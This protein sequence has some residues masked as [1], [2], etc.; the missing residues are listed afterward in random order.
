MLTILIKSHWVFFTLDWKSSLL[1][2]STD[3]VSVY[4]VHPP[5]VLKLTTQPPADPEIGPN[6]HVTRFPNGD[7][8]AAR[9]KQKIWN[10]CKEHEHTELYPNL[11]IVAGFLLCQDNDMKKSVVVALGSGCKCLSTPVADTDGQA[12]HD[13]H[14]VVIARRALIKFLYQQVTKAYSNSDNIF[15]VADNK[16]QL[17]SS[18]SLHLYVSSVPCGDARILE[19]VNPAV[20]ENSLLLPET[21]HTKFQVK[22]GDSLETVTTDNYADDR[23]QDHNAIMTDTSVKCM[24][25]S[26][27][28]AIWNVVGVQGALLSHFMHPVYLQSITIGTRAMSTD[29]HLQRAFFSRLGELEGLPPKFTT[30]KPRIFIPVKYLEGY[31]ARMPTDHCVISTSWYCGAGIELIDPTIGKCES[32]HPSRLSKS[33]LY[34]EYLKLKGWVKKTQDLSTTVGQDSTYYH[35]KQNAHDYQH[36][37][38]VFRELMEEKGCGHWLRKPKELELFSSGS[39]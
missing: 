22:E 29:D 38:H 2:A 25:C 7:L 18:L 9:C 15:V 6:I 19:A 4:T 11:G 8:I 36:A 21:K 30:C 26:D 10:F 13:L 16:L 24:S 35:D 33:S 28:I 1:G 27:K 5:D 39:A 17:H 34:Q 32:T 20:G 31:H 12:L 3:A 23:V 37:K 14:A